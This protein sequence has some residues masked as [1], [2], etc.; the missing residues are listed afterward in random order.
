MMG[1]DRM[2][3]MDLTLYVIK[4]K[5]GYIKCS[6]LDDIQVVGIEKA[7]V[8]PESKLEYL[9]DMKKEVE[10]YFQQVRIAKLCLSEQDYY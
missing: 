1:N 8:F 10:K 7:S 6:S 4:T 3:Y 2:R 9:Q 5:E